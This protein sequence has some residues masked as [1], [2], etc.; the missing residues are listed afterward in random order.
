MRLQKYIAKCGVTSRRK[1]E[2]L[3]LDG[4]ISVD[5]IVITEMGYI[6]DEFKSIVTYEE[7]QIRLEKERIVILINKPIG[8]VSTVDDQFNRNTVIDLIPDIEERLYPIGRLDYNSSGLLLLTNDGDLTYRLTHP[9]HDVSKIYMVKINS[10]FTI[11]DKLEFE[12]GIIIDGYKTKSSELLI[13]ESTTYESLL[14]ITLHEGRNNQIRKMLNELGHE[15]VSLER[16]QIG[17]LKD[18]SLA[19]GNYRYLTKEEINILEGKK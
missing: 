19:I 11:E 6:I 15:V 7:K 16:I 13:I 3:I 12:K 4:K 1:A 14:E 10:M 17:K 2:K 5:G 18:S 8:Y 9:K